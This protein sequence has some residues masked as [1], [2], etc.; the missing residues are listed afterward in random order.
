MKQLDL[1]CAEQAE[2]T[3]RHLTREKGE[4]QIGDAGAILARQGPYAM[5]LY[6]DQKKFE[7]LHQGI[8]ELLKAVFPDAQ[9]MRAR[10]LI[11]RVAENLPDLLLARRVLNQYLS[12]LK[13]HL[14]A[15]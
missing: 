13:Y 8:L 5:C 11:K 4:K 12:Y 7:S 3:A 1:I 14:K 9:E 6:L 2:A 15:E 10:E